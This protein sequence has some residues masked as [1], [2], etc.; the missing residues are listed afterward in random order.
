V[1]ILQQLLL[2]EQ[3]QEQEQAAV[4]VSETRQ[5]KCSR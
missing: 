3:E 4:D 5:E 1:W 2:Q